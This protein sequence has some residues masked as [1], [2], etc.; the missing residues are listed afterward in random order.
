MEAVT[1]EIARGT[2]ARCIDV[3]AQLAWTYFCRFM[4]AT[5]LFG[6]DR[7]IKYFTIWHPYR[8]RWALG[9]Q[10]ED[11]PIL[12]LSPEHG[13]DFLQRLRM[14][15]NHLRSQ[16]EREAVA[17]LADHLA[18]FMADIHANNQASTTYDNPL[19]SIAMPAMG[20]A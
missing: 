20:R 1:T 19:P 17:L 15:H 16:E 11:G 9:I 7:D 8:E 2:E 4:F 14:A 13:D 18:E 3:E 5:K 6:Q 10:L 12:A